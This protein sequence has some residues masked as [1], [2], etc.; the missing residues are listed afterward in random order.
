MERLS[1][2]RAILFDLDGT[3]IDTVE[4]I[5][6]ALNYTY[7]KHLGIELP[8]EELRRLIGLPLKMQ[9]HYLDERV[10]HPIDHEAMEADEMDYYERHRHLERVLPEVVDAVRE[11]HRRGYRTA[12]VTSKNRKELAS[13]LPRLNLD[14]VVEAI[15]SA[16]DSPRPKPAPDPVLTALQRVQV[17]PEAA[18]FI[19]DTVFDIE[20]G[21]AAG[22]QVGAVGW[23]AHLPQDLQAAQPDY[24]FATPADLLNW[25]RQLPERNNDGKAQEDDFTRR[26][27]D[28]SAYRA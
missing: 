17:R 13:V 24:Y 14:S 27:S 26:T 25:V 4:L 12:L 15:V 20:C 22:V 8:K 28:H 10:A 23:G 9:M 18:V 6:Q 5:T 3:L 2:V 19:G 21:R 11:A 7:R 16:D 1:A